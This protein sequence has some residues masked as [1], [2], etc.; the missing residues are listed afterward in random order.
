MR[1]NRFYLKSQVTSI[2]LEFIILVEEKIGCKSKYD[3]KVYW[4]VFPSI[5]LPVAMV[6]AKPCLQKVKLGQ[7][8]DFSK[9]EVQVYKNLSIF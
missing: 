1:P 8:Q 7:L 5:S 3:T 4:V 6:G 9:R 2:K